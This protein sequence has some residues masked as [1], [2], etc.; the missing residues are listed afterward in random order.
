[1]NIYEILKY[2]PHRYPFLLIDRIITF[3]VGKSLVAIKNVSFNE[4]FFAGHFPQRPVMHGVMIL[5]ALAQASGVLAYLTTNSRTGDGYLY[6][7]A[8]IDNTRFKRVVEPGDQLYL[9]V[10]I[11]RAKQDIWKFN[12]IARV[13]N[14]IVCSTEMISAKRKV[15]S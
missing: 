5:E 15:E 11:V 4:P 14:Q 9:E 2:L 13:D 7:F 6:Y 10:E 12:G 8:G 1:M 3:E